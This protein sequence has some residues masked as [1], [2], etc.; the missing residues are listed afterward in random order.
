MRHLK[1]C[2]LIASL[3]AAGSFANGAAAGVLDGLHQKVRV[4]S[5]LCFADH[6]HAGSSF[7]APTKGH[8]LQ[9]AIK[10]WSGFTVLEYGQEWGNFSLSWAKTIQCQPSSHGQWSCQIEARPCRAG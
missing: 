7:G 4:G 9:A 6:S 3:A 2:L 1:S 8:A 5:K 10:D